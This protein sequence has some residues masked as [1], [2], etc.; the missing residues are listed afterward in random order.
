MKDKLQLADDFS[1]RYQI[2]E[3]PLIAIASREVRQRI[4]ER[5]SVRY[6]IPRAVEAYIEDKGLYE[7]VRA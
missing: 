3:A 4:A 1:L 5:H 7:T 2:V 6:L